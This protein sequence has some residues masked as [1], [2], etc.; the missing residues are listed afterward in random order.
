[1]AKISSTTFKPKI[2]QPGAGVG[3]SPLSEG[4]LNIRKKVITVDAL[5][6]HRIKRKE[7]QQAQLR[8][9]QEKERSVLQR[10]LGRRRAGRRRRDD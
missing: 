5:T 1:M 9:E 7:K 2:S 4:L 8:K 6:R 10:R 3:Q